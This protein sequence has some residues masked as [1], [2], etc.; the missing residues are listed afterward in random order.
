MAPF[1]KVIS[2]LLH[3]INT[4]GARL[5][6]LISLSTVYKYLKS[7]GR[8]IIVHFISTDYTPLFLIV[9]NSLFQKPRL[10]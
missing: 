4:G 3:A 5:E 7:K 8:I 6:I 1:E 10:H 2:C 9:A